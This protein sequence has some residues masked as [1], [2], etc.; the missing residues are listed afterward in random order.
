MFAA[1]NSDT[2]LVELLM[3]NGA[4]PHVVDNF[5][6]TAFYVAVDHEDDVIFVKNPNSKIIELLSN[7]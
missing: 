7:Y 2:D 3:E 6:H 1:R 5:N 4:D